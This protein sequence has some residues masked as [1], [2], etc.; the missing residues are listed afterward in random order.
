MQGQGSAAAPSFQLMFI[1]GT[2]TMDAAIESVRPFR[3]ADFGGRVRCP[4]LLMH[5]IEDKQV[6]MEDARAM[7]DAIGS[8]DKQLFL[9]DDENGGAAHTQFDN[10]LPA[11][12]VCADWI[13]SKL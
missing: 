12:Q 11:L 7:Y 5:G 9:F 4:F 2:D 1:T 8:A 13:A 3:V 6:S 10:H